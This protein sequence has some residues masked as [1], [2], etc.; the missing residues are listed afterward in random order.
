MNI[1]YQ[2]EYGYNIK[3]FLKSM[4]KIGLLMSFIYFLHSTNEHGS[5]LFTKEQETIFYYAIMGVMSL[6]FLIHIVALVNSIAIGTTYLMV[7]DKGFVFP[8]SVFRG[9]LKVP[10]EQIRYVSG[11][12]HKHVKGLK[13]GF[14][15]TSLLI[16]SDFF[17]MP[18]EFDHFVLALQNELGQKRKVS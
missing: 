6:G 15:N 16:L 18:G 17:S 13:V 4:F 12:G 3:S 7:T 1:K 14:R 5:R 9:E 11:T 10:F 8:P 2:F